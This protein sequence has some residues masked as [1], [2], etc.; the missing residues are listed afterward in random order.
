MGINLDNCDYCHGNLSTGCV[1]S[2]DGKEDVLHYKSKSCDRCGKKNWKAVDFHG[3]GH[4]HLRWTKTI[5]SIVT[6]VREK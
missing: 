4:D 3:S 2:W 5:E 1:S 6:K